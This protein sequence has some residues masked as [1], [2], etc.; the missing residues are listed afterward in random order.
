MK[1]RQPKRYKKSPFSLFQCWIS[2]E[3]YKK[4]REEIKKRNITRRQFL[5]SLLE[6]NNK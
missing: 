1:R 4:I 6:K 2:R 5:M 3:E